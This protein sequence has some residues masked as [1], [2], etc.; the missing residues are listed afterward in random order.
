MARRAKRLR[1][2]MVV[3]TAGPT[4]EYLDPI[5]FLTNASSGQMGYA[6]AAEAARLGAQVVLVSGPTALAPPRGVRLEQVE[7]AQEMRAA[8][9]RS[10]RQAQII[11]GAAAVTD[12]SP[13]H[14]A[15]TKLKRLAGP[16]SV[17][18]L[19]TPDIWESIARSTPQCSQLRI[20]FA[21]EMDH[22]LPRAQAKLRAKQLDLIV[23]NGLETLGNE[24]A[25][26]ILLDRWGHRRSFPPL[27]KPLL[28]RRLWGQILSL[29]KYP[30][31]RHP[32]VSGNDDLFF[33]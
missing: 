24:R 29:T 4:R 22:L 3:V 11:V 30:H 25:R 20:G 2:Q 13:G 17:T 32:R 1:G 5:R 12:F 9:L 31:A 23:A 14:R 16:R 26:V 19:P 7:T 6:M 28:A 18:L 33:I 21:L 15:R 27:A 8:V 10:A